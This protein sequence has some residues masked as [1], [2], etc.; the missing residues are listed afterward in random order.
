MAGAFRSHVLPILFLAVITGLIYAQCLSHEF[1]V[2]WD[3]GLYVTEN[4]AVHGLSWGNIYDMFS[5]YYVGNYA[6]LQMLSYA[7]DYMVWGLWPG[8]YALTNILLHSANGLLLYLLVWRI[9]GTRSA[10]LIAAALFLAHPLQVESVAWISQRKNV[11]SMFFFLLSLLSYLKY[12]YDA[13]QG[14]R[15]WLALSVLV[16]AAA[17]LSKSVAIVLPV[18]LVLIDISLPGEAHRR[19]TLRDKL[20]YMLIAIFCGIMALVSQS[21][22]NM[23]GGRGV[24]L[25]GSYLVEFQTMLPVFARYLALLFWPEG[26]SA[27][28][29][30]EIRLYLDYQVIL[31]GILLVLILAVLFLLFRR[32]RLL[33]FWYALFLVGFIP[34]SQIVP[35][36][37]L[38]NDRYCYFPMLGFAGGV[39]TVCAS[40]FEK[41]GQLQKIAFASVGC[42][43]LLILIV[44]SNL[45]AAVWKDAVTLWSATSSR[46]ENEY[47]Y[48][49]HFVEGALA[50]AYIRRAKRKAQNGD[51]RHAA[52]D[53]LSAITIAP[54]KYEVL[55][56][57]G[58]HFTQNGKLLLG[59]RYLLRLTEHYPKSYEAW[60]NLG[61]NLLMAKEFDQA[62][63]AAHKALILRPGIGKAR[64]LLGHIAMETGKVDEAMKEYLAAEIAGEKSPDLAYNLA[65]LY[66]RSGQRQEAKALARLKQAV[67]WG[68]SDLEHMRSDPDL[69]SL[70]NLPEFKRLIDSRK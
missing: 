10:A 69:E 28:Y 26:L 27:V 14:G 2:N 30:P 25:A 22:E 63:E 24:H 51:G 1:L 59:R 61:F 44:V 35:L 38:M 7:I 32:N 33:F 11:L 60:L 29:S 56:G 64:L 65:C 18:V 45:R 13:Q 12:R 41:L 49:S 36:I 42:V 55:N 58:V 53:Y 5:N 39:G 15:L 4:Q 47:G 31:A 68:Y 50:D 20:P 34:V 16:F 9:N 46:G 43:V 8:G 40:M 21:A 23:G 17:I 57:A 6:P 66:V 67:S 48:D 62:M 52:E 19:V 70:R 37:T 3:D 54:D